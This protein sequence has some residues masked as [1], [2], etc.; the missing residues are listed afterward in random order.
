MAS[1]FSAEQLIY[2][3]PPN[4]LEGPCQTI[5]DSVHDLEVK[6]RLVHWKTFGEEVRAVSKTVNWADF[7]SAL[8]YY[9]STQVQ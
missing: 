1:S 7:P 5:S 4:L 9:A 2:S 6:A 3:S 8:L